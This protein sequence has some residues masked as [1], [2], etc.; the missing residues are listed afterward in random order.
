MASTRV[1]ILGAG[2]VGGVMAMDL[3]SE[4]RFRVTVADASAEALQR[5]KARMHGRGATVQAD[6]SN[7]KEIKALAASADVVLGA[8]PSRLGFA[9]LRAVIEV[10]R[11]YVDISF[12]AEEA[13]DL[14]R[15]A[16]KRGVTAVV[17]MGVAPG[18]SNL[19]AGV[20]ARELSPCRTI[21]I[22]VG[23]LPVERR[24][25][26][27]Y[28][29]A[30]S[31][32]DVIE[33]YT[34]PARLV[35]GGQVVVRE[36]LSGIE[37]VDLPGVGT[38]EAF[39][40]DGLRSLVRTLKVPTMRERTLRYPGHA[41]LMKA[42]RDAGFFDP[43]PIMVRGVDGQS[44]GVRPLDVTHR[45]LFPKWSYGPGERDLTVLRV[46]ATGLVDRRETTLRWDLLDHLDESTSATSMARTTAFPATLV[47]RLILSGK[48]DA[49]G[50]LPPERLA[51]SGPVVEGILDGLRKRGVNLSFEVTSE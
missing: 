15:L 31:P 23:G 30:F 24:L 1:L 38:L 7:P 42:F 16:K 25:P 40:T 4:R 2:M 39:N 6:C 20:A 36:A 50:V 8:L 27:E 46:E 44:V 49:P 21:D 43:T 12:M 29:A 22:M 13:L 18:L 41:T 10:E 47:A 48:I 33:E 5:A 11:P 17:D 37:P 51:D 19:L 3:A 34:R 26:F 35:E 14:D 32:S 45:L 9:A 28:K